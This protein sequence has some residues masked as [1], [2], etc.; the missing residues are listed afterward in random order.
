MSSF[1]FHI[2]RDY[3]PFDQREYALEV[4]YSV[5]RY[6]PA[7]YLQPEEGGEV[8][9]L[10][11]TLDGEEFDLTAAEEDALQT[12]AEEE[13]ARHLAEEAADYADWQY[14]QYRDR[15]HDAMSIKGDSA[16]SMEQSNG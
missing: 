1:T 11:V 14:E 7:T 4:T 2:E 16:Q 6:S 10:S 3:G 12:Q 8:E 13:A 15:M 9:I 5:S